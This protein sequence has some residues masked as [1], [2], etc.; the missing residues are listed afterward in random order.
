MFRKLLDHPIWT[1]LGTIAAIIALIVPFFE[2]ISCV[3]QSEEFK[4]C[5][6]AG[7][8]I[9]SFA[10][11]EDVTGSSGWVGGGLDQPTYCNQLKNQ[12]EA[13]VG[14]TIYWEKERSSEGNNK[15]WKGHVTYNYH[16]AIVGHWAPTYKLARTSECGRNE[17]VT[18]TSVLTP[19]CPAAGTRIGFSLFG[20]RLIGWPWA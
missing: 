6:V 17:A 14:Q 3:P 20:Y 18:P 15:D 10:V 12:K 4:Q 8:G 2:T 19:S 5:R 16:C 9:E 11:T 13:A 7:N 1:A